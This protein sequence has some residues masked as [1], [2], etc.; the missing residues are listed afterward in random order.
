MGITPLS[1]IVDRRFLWWGQ[2][3]VQHCGHFWGCWVWGIKNPL[4][5]EAGG[6]ICLFLLIR[7]VQDFYFFGH[8]VINAWCATVSQCRVVRRY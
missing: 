7:V 6:V 4:S 5:V 3:V 1:T 2:I 8:W